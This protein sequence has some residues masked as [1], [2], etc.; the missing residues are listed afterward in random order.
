MITITEKLTN[1]I[2]KVQSI[3]ECADIATACML[4]NN[5][6]SLNSTW[7]GEPASTV[8][9]FA[10]GNYY[11]LKTIICIIKLIFTLEVMR[12]SLRWNY[13]MSGNWNYKDALLATND[14]N[15]RKWQIIL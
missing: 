6:V 12:H 15:Y 13:A 3:G 4:C 14:Y 5:V 9:E 10:I 8:I 2:V 11:P 1:Y 7:L